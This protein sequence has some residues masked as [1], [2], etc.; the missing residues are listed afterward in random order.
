MEEIRLNIY[1][2]KGQT[3]FIT[4]RQDFFD[5]G[6]PRFCQDKFVSTLS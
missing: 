1:A 3:L 2:N 5:D 6:P 4:F